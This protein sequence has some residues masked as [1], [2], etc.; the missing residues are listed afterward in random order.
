MGM[1][2]FPRVLRIPLD[3]M[4]VGE[5]DWLRGGD[6][7]GGRQFHERLRKRSSR[8]RRSPTSW[9]GAARAARVHGIHGYAF[10]REEWRVANPCRKPLPSQI[11]RASS[12]STRQRVSNCATFNSVWAESRHLKRCRSTAGQK[13][14]EGH[15]GGKK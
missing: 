6:R 3:G 9:Q 1:R 14:V 7:G 12:L 10:R 5:L 4:T 13:T 8:G 15:N 11:S 2:H